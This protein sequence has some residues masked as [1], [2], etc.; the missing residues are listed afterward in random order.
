MD[1]IRAEAEAAL[2]TLRELIRHVVDLEQVYRSSPALRRSSDIGTARELALK[3]V[4]EAVLPEFTVL[5]QACIHDQESDKFYDEHDL[6]V[7]DPRV[8]SHLTLPDGR[9]VWIDPRGVHAVIEVKST[10]TTTELTKAL[11][12]VARVQRAAR[13][14]IGEV[15]LNY[16]AGDGTTLPY[17][18]IRAGIFAFRSRLS[19]ATVSERVTQWAVGRPPGDWPQFVTV[20]DRGHLS[21]WNLATSGRLPWPH[22]GD[23]LFRQEHHPGKTDETA[24]LAAMASHLDSLVEVFHV[25]GTKPGRRSRRIPYGVGTGIPVLPEGVSDPQRECPHLCANCAEHGRMSFDEQQRS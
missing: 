3:A 23:K 2:V 24:P 10:L 7:A 13:R 21:W 14:A 11:D 8:D 5:H 22:P 19:L 16:Q 6:V 20:L 12:H 18:P 15:R 25:P 9:R 4:V 1:P 17:I